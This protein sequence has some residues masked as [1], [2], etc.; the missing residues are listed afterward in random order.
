MD[1]L[2]SYQQATS[3]PDWL[4]L[5]A[6]YVAFADY[7]AL[8]QVS[9]RFW[10]VFAP[11]L[12]G[13]PCA[14]SKRLGWS[15]DDDTRHWWAKFMSQKLCQL[16]TQTRL[17]IRVLDARG[18]SG[19]LEF[20]MYPELGRG[21]FYSALGLLPN[22]EA[23]ILDDHVGLDV[24]F[25]VFNHTQQA[26]LG[27]CLR[28]LSLINVSSGLLSIIS[29]SIHLPQLIYLDIS[30]TALPQEIFD[31]PLPTLCILKLR[32]NGIRGGLGFDSS[33]FGRQLWSLDLSN[34]KLTDR[35]V[36]FVT[37][38]LHP[39]R[40]LRTLQYAAT[41]G[42]LVPCNYMPL[43]YIRE[44]HGSSDMFLPGDRYLVDAPA[45]TTA[46]NGEMDP[47]T[48]ARSDGSVPVRPDSLS[49][50]LSLLSRDCGNAALGHLP[51]SIGLTHL[52]LSGNDLSAVGIEMLLRRT[53]GQIELFDCDSMTLYPP[54]PRSIS[55]DGYT[56]FICRDKIHASDS[57]KMYGFSGLSQVFRPVWC[58]NLRSLR[59]HHS[60]VTNIPSLETPEFDDIERIF[61]AEKCL[62]PWLDWAYSFAFLPDMNPR[63]QSL[64]LTCVPRQSYG[65]LVHKLTFFLRLLG[66][67]EQVL[68]IMNEAEASNPG[69]PV[70]LVSGLRHLTL[71]IGPREVESEESDISLELD[72]EKL[73][74]TGETPFSFFNSP[75]EESFSL[76]DDEAEQ[77][78]PTRQ[79]PRAIEIWS[80]MPA[81]PNE[82]GSEAED[83]ELCAVE[84]HGQA[85]PPGY[86]RRDLSK[87]K[88][89]RYKE[90]SESFP[91]VVWAGNGW[92]PSPV[93]QMY[94]RLVLEFGVHSGLGP[95][96]IH[97][98]RAGAP[99]ECLLFLETWLFAALPQTMAMPP[100]I[101]SPT[102][103]DVAAELQRRHV[104]T[105]E[106]FES[107]RQKSPHEPCFYW[108]GTLEI[109]ETR[110]NQKR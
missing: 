30:G 57:V 74:T 84:G 96:T 5:A 25:L 72:A 28:L 105:Y 1:I 39:S 75:A 40:Q 53:N 102:Y 88:W 93:V 23:L 77:Q 4:Q 67:Q 73:M 99:P 31:L 34:N 106:E 90:T 24:R 11:R 7:P 62:L 58:S 85:A 100:T 8:C 44:V 51:Q 76:F 71:E 29:S 87:E 26:P 104:S 20:S 13:D 56:H 107:R 108:G 6:P 59:I 48:G 81:P 82:D 95:A 70:R 60:F 16:T 61:A 12:W 10:S 109:I 103:E 98:T 94:R 52:H 49:G 2:P 38:Q 89:I 54:P 86:A 47:G 65:P 50:V 3:R 68:S 63:L 15:T 42:V 78:P 66:L 18:A 64:T 69:R 19:P 43:F 110:P 80:Q 35:T 22:V 97:H 101:P 46:A 9:R 91:V 33:F 21:V 14:A 17:L 32:R 41:E 36:N 37:N 27:R 45:F 79:Q 92:S 55:R 83:V